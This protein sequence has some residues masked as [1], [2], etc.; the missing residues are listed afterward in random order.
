MANLA[1]SKLFTTALKSP[2]APYKINPVENNLGPTVCPL[3]CNSS[4]VK[5]AFVCTEG[6]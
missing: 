1:S 3:F 4:K 6:S 2:S 5:A